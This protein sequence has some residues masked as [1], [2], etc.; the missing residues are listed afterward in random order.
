MPKTHPR[1]CIYQSQTRS[2]SSGQLLVTLENGT[3]RHYWTTVTRSNDIQ[4]KHRPPN[5]W[6]I[7]L[8][9]WNW[10]T[11][12]ICL[13]DEWTT[14]DDH[15]YAS[16]CGLWVGYDHHHHHDYH[17]NSCIGD[18]PTCSASYDGA[19]GAIDNSTVWTTSGWTVNRTSS[20]LD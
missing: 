20:S 1:I 9:G 10:E 11:R 3:P 16:N 13:R 8:K 7:F 4:E 17:N 15:Y 19:S 18:M 5:H 12:T 2:S 6:K 14:N